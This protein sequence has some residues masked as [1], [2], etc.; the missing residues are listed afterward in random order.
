MQNNKL[1][2][3]CFINLIKIRIDDVVALTF[4]SKLKRKTKMEKP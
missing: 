3:Y 4:S 1:Y 2:L